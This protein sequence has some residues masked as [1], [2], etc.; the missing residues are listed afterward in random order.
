MKEDLQFCERSVQRVC[1]CFCRGLSNL[2]IFHSYQP[3]L[4]VNKILM[5]R[6]EKQKKSEL[7]YTLK[8]KPVSN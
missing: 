6:L 8:G 2:G 1:G 5:V 7:C 4:C 3:V